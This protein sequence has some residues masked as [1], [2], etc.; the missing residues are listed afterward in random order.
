MR[1]TARVISA[2]ASATASEGSVPAVRGR[3][4][5]L[6][7][8]AGAD[9]ARRLPVGVGAPIGRTASRGLV[10]AW[11]TKRRQVARN[12][13]R[14]DARLTGAALERAVQSV[15]TYYG[16]YWH[17]LFRLEESVRA[18]EPAR[19]E[20]VGVEH[21]DAAV[22]GGRGAIVGLPHLG[23]YDFAGAWLATRGMRPLAVAEPVEPPELFEWFVRVRRAA[24]IDVVA[25][26][27]EAAGASLAALRDG[28]VVCLVCDRDLN[29][30]GVCVELFGEETTLPAGPAVLALR[31]GAPLLPTATYFTGDRGHV[32]RILPPLDTT[33]RGSLREDVTRVTRE[34]AAAFE[35]LIAAA[36][37]QWLVMQ[38]V[39][40]A[41]R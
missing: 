14:V 34:L 17:E 11:P 36:P 20:A 8:R 33:R 25:L 35:G 18:G 19:M 3:A 6:A 9:L 37:E 2:S 16:R 41:D 29:G 38:P 26:G 32:A 31:S 4:A 10:V 13:A 12:L 15:F 7:Y 23:N 22:A 24:G 39:W 5:Y 1:A 28:R 40:T 21:L 27:P 30:D